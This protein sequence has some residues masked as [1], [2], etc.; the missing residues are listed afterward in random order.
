MKL[1][2]GVLIWGALLNIPYLCRHV[3]S[4]QN[5]T[6]IEKQKRGDRFICGIII[7]MLL[8]VGIMITFYLMFYLTNASDCFESTLFYTAIPTFILVSLPKDGHGIFF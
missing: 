5:L 1:L 2:L 4:M 6:E 7:F 8:E 3:D